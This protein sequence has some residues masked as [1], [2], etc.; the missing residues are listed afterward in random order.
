METGAPADIYSIGVMLFEMLTGRVPFDG[1]NAVAIAM[2]QVAE[3][4]PRRA[5]LNPKVSPAL[6][7]VV[8]KALA[9]DPAD[10]F[11]TADGDVGRARRRR[12][13]PGA[14]AGPHRALRG[15]SPRRR[16]RAGCAATAGGSSRSLALLLAAGALAY[17]LTRARAGRPCPGSRARSEP[18]GARSSCRTPASRSRPTRIENAGSGGHRDRAGP[19]RRHRGRGRLDRDDHRQPRAGDGGGAAGRRPARS[20]EAQ[21]EARGRRLRGHGPA[22]A[23]SDGGQGRQGDRHRAGGRHRARAGRRRSTLFV[24]T[25]VATETVPSVVGLDRAEADQRARGRRLR[26]QRREPGLRRARGPGAEPGPG[27]R[28]APPRSAPR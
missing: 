21:R 13:G 20:A 27:R 1:E 15:S 8:L 14:L 3:Q 22:T 4:P 6:D 16:R 17:F 7:A 18:D 10:R 23:S 24:S 9:K 25:G 5:T 2:K 12:G 28:D 26:R 11:A 19:A